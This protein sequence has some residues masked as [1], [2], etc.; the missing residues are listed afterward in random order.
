[1]IGKLCLLGDILHC[2]RR[3]VLF[4]IN[5]FGLSE[6]IIMLFVQKINFANMAGNSTPSVDVDSSRT[7]S[8][9]DS[10]SFFFIFFYIFLNVPMMM[11]APAP[12]SH[13]TE[14]STL[15]PPDLNHRKTLFLSCSPHTQQAIIQLCQALNGLRDDA[16]LDDVLSH[17]QL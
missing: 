8:C 3:F 2:F 9:K 1:M 4:A 10:H 17:I 14:Q 11:Q 5:S 12:P 6:S 16:S 7:P 13:D 15:L